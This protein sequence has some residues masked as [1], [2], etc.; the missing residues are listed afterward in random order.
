[1]ESCDKDRVVLDTFNDTFNEQFLG[2]FQVHLPTFPSK[3]LGRGEVLNTPPFPLS[4]TPIFLA[5]AQPPPLPCL[6]LGSRWGWEAGLCPPHWAHPHL[7]PS[8][9]KHPCQVFRLGT[10]DSQNAQETGGPEDP[11][12]HL[13]DM[14]MTQLKLGVVSWRYVLGLRRVPVLVLDTWGL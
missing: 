14:L 8:L 2:P 10:H 7:C 1:M 3:P 13:V 9:K 12:G 5:P 11:C 6:A 4:R